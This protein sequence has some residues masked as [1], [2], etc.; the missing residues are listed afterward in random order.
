MKQS[1]NEFEADQEGLTEGEMN[2]IDMIN[3]LMW[4]DPNDTINS[5]KASPRGSGH[6][7]G[8]TAVNTFLEDNGLR[9]II[10]SH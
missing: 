8:T 6:H 9:M 1:D 10:R 7:F 2:I 4:S 5:Y 3:D